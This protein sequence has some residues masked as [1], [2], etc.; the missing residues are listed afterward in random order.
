MSHVPVIAFFNNQGRVGRTTLAQHL[1]WMYRELELRVL[2]VDLDPQADLT[3]ALLDE[4][5]LEE[6]WCDESDAPPEAAPG[7]RGTVWDALL[8]LASGVGDILEPRLEE[9]DWALHLIAGDIGLSRFEEALSTSWDACSDGDARAFRMQSAFWRI[10]QSAARTLEARVVIVD[11]GPNLGAINRS[12]L[13]ASDHV[14]FPIAP[15]LHSQQ[16][17]KNVGATLRAWR[18]QWAER[19][20]RNPDPALE[21]PPGRMEPVGYV[22]LH[23]IERLSRPVFS[24]AKWFERV[25][26][27]YAR[28]IL[29]DESLSGDTIRERHQL[30]KLRN[31]HGLMHLG[32]EAR[33][34]VFHLREA[35]GVFGS[36]STTVLRSW[37]EFRDLAVGIATRAGIELPPRPEQLRILAE[38]EA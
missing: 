14:V 19:R 16:G 12:V 38:A 15:D 31:F 28:S 25:P 4:D 34:P 22:F 2:L 7:R 23:R 36:H 32:K 9:I 37:F 6:I 20:A 18:D 11:L 30:S 10:A 8:P 26:F 5:R 24:Y 1:A 3:A 17:L 13:V 21:L 27:E 29:C 33:K 35:D